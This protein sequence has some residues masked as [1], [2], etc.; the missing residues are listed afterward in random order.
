MRPIRLDVPSACCLLFRVLLLLL[1]L[2]GCIRW[3]YLK[4]LH[5]ITTRGQLPA[6]VVLLVL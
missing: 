4:H 3:S 5:Y 1:Q 6:L 2:L